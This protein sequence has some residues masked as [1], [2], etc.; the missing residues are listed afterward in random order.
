LIS[1]NQ[2]AVL[3]EG[4]WQR[5][6]LKGGGPKKTAAALLEERAQLNAKHRLFLRKIDEMDVK[7]QVAFRRYEQN[8]TVH[9]ASFEK[10]IDEE[11]HFYQEE[12]ETLKK[13]QTRTN[14]AEYN[15]IA[16]GVLESIITAI[17]RD[18]ALRTKDLND[19]IEIFYHKMNN[20]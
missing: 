13:L 5:L 8:P 10:V 14:I 4:E 1:S 7:T 15:A 3:K 17:R 18:K 6:S 2:F 19:A 11:R 20:L 9:R 12:L 16:P